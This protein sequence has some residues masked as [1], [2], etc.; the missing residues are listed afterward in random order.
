M[1][2]EYH[3]HLE[4][5]WCV[6]LVRIHAS[7]AQRIRA[8]PF[9]RNPMHKIHMCEV[10]SRHGKKKNKK[11]SEFYGYG[12]NIY[13]SEILMQRRNMRGS[14][15]TRQL[16]FLFIVIRSFTSAKFFSLEWLLNIW[17]ALHHSIEKTRYSL[18]S[19]VI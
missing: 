4:T 7:D 9:L 8:S 19:K 18:T 13:G 14:T 10:R 1:H 11:P 17:L 16:F 15:L 6:C 5:T 2:Y 3:V 12:R